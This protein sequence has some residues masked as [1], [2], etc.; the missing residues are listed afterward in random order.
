M[1]RRTGKTSK[2]L[3]T[4]QQARS[5]RTREAILR[6]AVVCFDARGYDHTTTAAIARRAGVA[7]GT[8]YGYF[9]DKRA[10]L[11]ELATATMDEIATYVVRNLD[12]ALWRDADPRASVRSL[13]DALFH[14]RTFNPGMQR[15]IWERYFKDGEFRAAVQAI[16]Q[17]IRAAVTELFRALQ[18]ERRLRIDDL[19]TAAFI[20]YTAV[21][22]TAARLMLGQSGAEVDPAVKA[23]S[24][25]VSR[26]LF[27]DQ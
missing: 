3:R 6:A 24:D 18:R 1:P 2:R 23:A 13:I 17:R 9:R 15:I 7:V 27:R 12:P 25:M 21:E 19:P 26:F 10:I 5:R 20:I 16:E 14:T 4:P 11:L 22:W 8:L